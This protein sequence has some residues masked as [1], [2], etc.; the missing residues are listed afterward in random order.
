MNKTRVYVETTIPS[1]L[2]EN[3][4]SPENLARKHWTWLWWDQAPRFYELVSSTAVLDELSRGKNDNASERLRVIGPLPLL[5]IT[6][7][8]G[9]IVQTYIKHMVMPAEP[10]GDALHLAL[11]S[12]YKCDFLVT[13]NCVHLA[14]ANKFNHI[15]RINTLLGL[16]IPLVV[17]PLEL[18]GGN[19][20]YETR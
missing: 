4:I 11:A 14:N 6:P 20:D 1:F 7:E 18:V 16:F 9:E 2:C 13:W 3:R 5:P 19:S 17:T 15:R 10:A 8:I 12:Y